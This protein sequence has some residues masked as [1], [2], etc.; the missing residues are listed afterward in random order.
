MALLPKAVRAVRTYR[1]EPDMLR[2]PALWLGI[3]L[4]LAIIGWASYHMTNL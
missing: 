3:A 1:Q 4:G 2:S